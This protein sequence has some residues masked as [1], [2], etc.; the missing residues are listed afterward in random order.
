VPILRDLIGNLWRDV[1]FPVAW[2]PIAQGEEHPLGANRAVQAFDVDHVSSDRALGYRVIERRRRLRPE[3][4]SLPASEIETLAKQGRRGEMTEV[5]THLLFVHS[6]DAMPIAPAWAQGA[7]LLVHDATFLDG[8]D[9]REPIHATTEEALDVARASGVADLVLYHLSV[10][11]DRNTVLP[12]LAAQLASSGFAGGCWLLDEGA[13]IR[14]GPA[15]VEAG[16]V[17]A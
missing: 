5:H 9:R 16:R 3:F 11:Y 15:S 12:R 14:V 2:V 7:D 4:A 13:I 8:A 1:A 10:R 17:L 6:G